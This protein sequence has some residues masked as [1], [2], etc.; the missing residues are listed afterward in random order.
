M[1]FIIFFV[2]NFFEILHELGEKYKL[3]PAKEK[4]KYI[5]EENDSLN[6]GDDV[7]LSNEFGGEP[8]IE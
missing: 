5:Y 3:L 8:E 7:P 1:Y 2:N 6:N 4:A